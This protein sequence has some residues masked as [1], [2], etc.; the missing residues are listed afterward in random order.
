MAPPRFDT[1]EQFLA[2][3][4]ERH[5]A[6]LLRIIRTIQSEFPALEL[7]VAWN[8][9]HFKKGKHYVVGLSSLR[10][11]LAFS[12]WSAEV[13]DT[14][15]HSFGSLEATKNLIR[16]PLGWEVDRVLLRFLITARLDELA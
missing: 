1:V 2:A 6:T 9:P 15:R 4:P 5:R 10:N 8:V 13:M 14:Y 3:E 16:I 11:Y 7:T 12:P